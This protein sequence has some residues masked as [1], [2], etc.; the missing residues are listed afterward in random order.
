MPLNGFRALFCDD[1]TQ[2]LPPGGVR[3]TF[4]GT[5][6]WLL[7]DGE[8][9][10]LLDA[11]FTRPGFFKMLCG[12]LE[13][14][15]A[16]VD[17]TLRRFSV[18]RLAAVFLSHTHYDHAL[19]AAYVSART[20]AAL[21]GSRSAV[22]IGLGGGIPAARLHPFRPGE[23]YRIGAFAVTVLPSVHSRPT[24]LNNDLGVEITAPLTQ[25]APMRDYAEG[26][27]F[28]FLIRQGT[29]TLLVRPSCNYIPGALRG[30]RADTV[31]LGIGTMGKESDAFFETFWR[32]T[33]Q[34]VDAK[35][36]IPIHWDNFF[37][38][39]RA[40]LQPQTRLGDDVPR[41]LAFLRARCAAEGR[42]LALVDAFASVIL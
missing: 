33:V 7:D 3:M 20:G 39:L 9:Q 17:E 10:M 40:P 24:F 37:R 23:T 18:D 35:R 28:D 30:V 22:N 14:N 1:T 12:R 19:D 16:L 41:S 26:G 8:T 34:T 32:E 31:L 15:R 2:P 29:Q 4:F 21:Y 11:H 38:P 13:T 27:S 5:T 36:V 42:Q 25:P 6:T